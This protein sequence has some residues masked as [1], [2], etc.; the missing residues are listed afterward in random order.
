VNEVPDL[1]EKQ[2]RHMLF[3]DNNCVLPN[4]PE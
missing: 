4:Y 2:D 3:R 1:V